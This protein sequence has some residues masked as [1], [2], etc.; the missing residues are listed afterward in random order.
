MDFSQV[1]EGILLGYGIEIVELDIGDEYQ[2]VV[3]GNEFLED[4]GGLDFEG[5]VVIGFL[6]AQFLEL[7][8]GFHIIGIWRFCC[9]WHAM[10]DYWVGGVGGM[11][12]RVLHTRFFPGSPPREFDPGLKFHDDLL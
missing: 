2:F 6:S 9:R 5:L 4:I 12:V 1:G 3:V 7:A 10:P 11:N 8:E